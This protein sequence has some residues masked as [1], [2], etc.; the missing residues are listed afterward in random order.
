MF[1]GISARK[2]VPVE[3]IRCPRCNHRKTKLIGWFWECP[4]LSEQPLYPVCLLCGGT[5]R[6]IALS[7]TLREHLDILRFAD[8]FGETRDHIL[9]EQSFYQLQCGG[10]L[11]LQ[12]MFLQAREAVQSH[13]HSPAQIL[14]I[15]EAWTFMEQLASDTYKDALNREILFYPETL[16]A[17][18]DRVF[19]EFIARLGRPDCPRIDPYTIRLRLD[20]CA[21]ALKIL[22][23]RE[24]SPHLAFLLRWT[25]YE[26]WIRENRPKGCYAEQLS[27]ELLTDLRTHPLPRL[28][29]G[30]RAKYQL[31]QERPEGITPELI[32]ALEHS[33]RY[34]SDPD[35]EEH[36]ITLAPPCPRPVSLLSGHRNGNQCLALCITEPDADA[37][38]TP[39]IEL[40]DGRLVIWDPRIPAN[41]MRA[42]LRALAL[43][44]PPQP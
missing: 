31:P 39:V 43:E 9:R 26:I 11:F 30:M 37:D 41:S 40:G 29:R 19:T 12:R 17:I 28:T 34:Y 20:A 23:P 1:V 35:A 38:Q 15:A 5:G 3:K 13:D 7:S 14:A 22:G 2:G 27:R 16:P 8:V 18:Q 42:Y 36:E 44:P 32:A 33:V 4:T 24:E 6:K 10:P 21:R 25:V